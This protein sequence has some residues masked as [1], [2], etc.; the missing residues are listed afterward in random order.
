MTSYQ[1]IKNENLNVLIIKTESYQQIKN[2][3]LNV[4]IIKTESYQQFQYIF[5]IKI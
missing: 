3:N 5:F 1:Q 4:R 2:E